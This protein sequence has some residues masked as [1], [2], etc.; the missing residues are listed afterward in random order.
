M[1]V[2]ENQI[3]VLEKE[4]EQ[5]YRRRDAIRLESAKSYADVFLRKLEA[6]GIPLKVGLQAIRDLAKLN[7]PV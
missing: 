2:V 6:D 5:L 7:P 4:L 3:K 1:T